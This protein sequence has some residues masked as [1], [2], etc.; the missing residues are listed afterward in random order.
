MAQE[1]TGGFR[2]ARCAWLEPSRWMKPTT[3]PLSK[4]RLASL[5]DEQ[6]HHVHSKMA[7]C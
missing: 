1:R 4:V 7:A 2:W 5:V 6:V 3:T